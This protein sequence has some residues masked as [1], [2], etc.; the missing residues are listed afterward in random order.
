[1]SS[2]KMSMVISEQFVSSLKVLALNCLVLLNTIINFWNNALGLIILRI[3]SFVLATLFLDTQY[4]TTL[5][6]ANKT[7]KRNTKK[8]FLHLQGDID[9]TRSYMCQYRARYKNKTVIVHLSGIQI[10]F[11]PSWCYCMRRPATLQAVYV[12]CDGQMSSRRSCTWSN[13]L[14]LIFGIFFRPWTLAATS[15]RPEWKVRADFISKKKNEHFFA[16]IQGLVM[17]SIMVDKK[18]YFLRYFGNFF[19]YRKMWQRKH[20]ILSCWQMTGGTG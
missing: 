7:G 13:S 3:L 17:A 9:F 4:S 8:L 18:R 2:W 10:E 12:K 11:A 5:C 19:L 14:P 1:M 20:W 6:R 15:E 16:D